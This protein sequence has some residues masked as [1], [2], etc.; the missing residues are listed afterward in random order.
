MS[1]ACYVRFDRGHPDGQ[2][3]KIQRWLDTNGIQPAQ[4]AWYADEESGDAIERPE[5][6]RL[7]RNILEGEV[8]TVVLWNLDSLGPRL[9]EGMKILASW[10]ERRVKIVVVMQQIKVYGAAGEMLA[11]LLL[12]LT[13]IETEYRRSRQMAGIAAA[14]EKGAYL[15]RK[16]GTTKSQPA[17]ARELRDKGMTTGEIG[18][19]LGVSPRT[20]SRYLSLGNVAGCEGAQL[21]SPSISFAPCGDTR[22]P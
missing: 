2:R 5:F 17:R 11:A 18:Q 10:C 8:N 19:E 9:N 20:A 22:I 7:Q 15:G 1:V 6:D 21:P 14:K 4:V 16:P 13:K 3:A 12:G